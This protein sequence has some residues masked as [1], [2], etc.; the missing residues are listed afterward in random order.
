M[1]AV[2]YT[3][4]PISTGAVVPSEHILYEE[5]IVN[6]PFIKGLRLSEIFYEEA[7]KPILAAHL[8][9]LNYSAGR[10]GRGSDVLGFDTPQS[11]DHDWGPKLMLFL[12]EADY[13]THDE[14]DQALRREL[15]YDIHGYPTHFAYHDDARMYWLILNILT[16]SR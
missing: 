8:P 6:Q 14:I 11:M 3:P 16:N 5:I 9:H 1:L 15:P 12:A 2:E 7:V 13:E 4:P 10:L